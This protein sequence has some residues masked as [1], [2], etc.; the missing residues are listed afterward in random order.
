MT[1]SNADYDKIYQL[2]IHLVGI[3]PLIWRRFQIRGDTTMA[4]LH[5]IIQLV[6]DWSD[7]HLNCFKIHGRKYGVYHDGGIQFSDDPMDVRFAD[8]KPKAKWKFIYEYNL[9]L[10][11]E[12]QIRV[13][14]VLPPDPDYKYPTCI[15]GKRACIPED[16]DPKAYESFLLKISYLQMQLRVCSRYVQNTP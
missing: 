1:E 6:M 2:K 3:S 11:C 7:D 5:Y 14:K 9:T 12:H 8:L 13:E 10:S 15:S 4:E 16:V